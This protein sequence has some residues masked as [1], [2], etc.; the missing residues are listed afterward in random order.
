MHYYQCVM[1]CKQGFLSNV[2]SS[3]KTVFTLFFV[4]LINEL[5]KNAGCMFYADLITPLWH[6]CSTSNY[7]YLIKT[8]CLYSSLLVRI[9]VVFKFKFLFWSQFYVY[10]VLFT[11]IQI[12]LNDLLCFVLIFLTNIYYKVCI[13]SHFVVD[14]VK[15]V[16]IVFMHCLSN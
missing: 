4:L 7:I 1:D 15:F 5:A 8:N 11:L 2:W 10:I 13:L 16:I 12:A 6:K 14:K 3:S 9:S